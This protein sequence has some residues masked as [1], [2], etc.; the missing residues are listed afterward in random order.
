[1][2]CSSLCLLRFIVWSFRQGQTPVHPGSIQGG[3]VTG[4]KWELYNLNEDYSQYNDLAAKRPDKLAEL[5]KIFMQEAGKHQVFP[6]D[7]STFQRFLTARPSGTAGRN[8][9]TLNA[10]NLRV[11]VSLHLLKLAC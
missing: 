3:N 6:L 5:L 7:N 9:F 2:I 4:Y 1:M 10:L 8:E 11:Q